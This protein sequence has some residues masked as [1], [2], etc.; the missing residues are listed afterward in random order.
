MGANYK[1]RKVYYYLQSPIKDPDYNV[2]GKI[3][4]LIDTD[5]ERVDVEYNKSK[6]LYFERL[7][8]TSEGSTLVDVNNNQTSPPTEIEDCL[9][10]IIFFQSLIEFSEEYSDLKTIL[11]NSDFNISAQNSHEFID[12]RGSERKTIKMFFDDNDGYNKIRFAKKYV[13]LSKI[14]FFKS[15][16]EMKWITDLKKRINDHT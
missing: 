10:P 14:D 3:I 15:Q 6:Y 2:K 12:L 5:N 11:T 7:L 13:E 4:C 1:V 16:T 9:N 8:N